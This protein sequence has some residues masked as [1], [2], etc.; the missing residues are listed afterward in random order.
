MTVPSHKFGS[1][2]FAKVCNS[3]ELRQI[4]VDPWLDT[5]T[6]LIKPNWVSADPG[7]F[8]DARTLR[9]LFEVLDTRII[10]VESY[11]LGRA[12]NIL[13][14]GMTFPVGDCAANW[15]WL[16]T[17]KGWNWLIEN[18]D[19]GWFR[20]GNQW[21]HLKRE[22]QVF[23]DR[24]GFTELFD[25]FHVT[26]LNVTEEVWN[27][28]IADP[29]AIKGLVESRFKPV[30]ID[31]LYSLV[32]QKLYD[33]RGS[34]FI[35][36]ARL[37]MYGSFSMKNLFGMIPDPLRSWWHGSGHHMAAQ[38]ILDIN[39]VYHSLFA[40]FGI[41][42][43]IWELAYIHPDGIHQGVYSGKYNVTEGKGAIALGRNLLELDTILLGINDPSQRRIVDIINRA[44]ISLAQDEFGP[45][46]RDQIAEAR[47]KVQEWISL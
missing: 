1:T 21:E 42:E 39:K 11:C 33:L 34:T 30:Q 3:E 5:E 26:Y 19:W 22:E 31:K 29:E 13:K 15:R 47:D 44:P 25:E 18:P 28:R 36:L 23:L 9:M 4:L 10:I 45:V 8:T 2:T 38:N 41:C 43:A 27:G 40:M 24:F 17:G 35:S 46:D 12:M 6:I 20:D 37:K 14:D 32:P 7:E 16:L